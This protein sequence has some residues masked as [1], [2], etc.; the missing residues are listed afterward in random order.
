MVIVEENH[1]FSSI[2]GSADMPFYNQ[3]A[4]SY[5]LLTNYTGVSNPSEPNYLAMTSGSIWDNPQDKSQNDGTYPGPTVADQLVA[6]GIGWK[7]YAEDLPHA[8]DL[9]DDFSPQNYDV[10][11]N[12]FMYFDSIRN[13]PAQCARD[14]PFTQFAP[15]LASGAAPPF[16]FVAPNLINDMHDGSLQQGDAWLQ[17]AFAAIFAST[18]YRQGGVVVV[19]FDESDGSSDQLPVVVVSAKTRGVGRVSTPMDH[20][21]LLRGIE[22]TYGLPYLGAAADPGHGDIAPLLH[23]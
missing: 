16:I 11:H 3:L 22:E 9:T 23:R 17:A 15:D 7:A 12:P 6:R 1:G 4:S 13:S 8:C 10:N 2:I 20:Y 19:T 14:V 5:A 18:W 21:G